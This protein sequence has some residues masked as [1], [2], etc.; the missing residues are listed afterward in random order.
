MAYTKSYYHI[1]FRTHRSERTIEERHERELYMYAFAT[2]KN[3]GVKLWRINSMPDHIHM[4]VSLPPVMSVASFVKGIKQTL[5][6]YMKDNAKSFPM[7]NGWADGYCSITYCDKERDLVI[8]YIKKQK[9]HHKHVPFADEMRSIM[10]DA[11][12]EINDGYFKKDWEA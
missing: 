8:E 10:Q 3:H 12:I 7:F 5:G 9:E 1:I 2:C 6:N 4:L 11:G